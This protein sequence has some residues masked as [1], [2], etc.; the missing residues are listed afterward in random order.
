MFEFATTQLQNRQITECRP[1]LNNGDDELWFHQLKTTSRHGT[2]FSFPI[3]FRHVRRARLRKVHKQEFPKPRYV[4]ARAS[5]CVSDHH[6]LVVA[7]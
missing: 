6:L 1:V 2:P 7:V 5:D 3:E 4:D